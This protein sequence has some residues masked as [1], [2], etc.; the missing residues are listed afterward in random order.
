MN[1]ESLEDNF[2]VRSFTKEDLESAYQMIQDLPTEITINT[3]IHQLLSPNA[4]NPDQLQGFV[5]LSQGNMI[6]LCLIS[7]IDTLSITEQYAI[8]D[9][10]ALRKTQSQTKRIR[11]FLMQPWYLNQS[12]RFAR[13]VMIQSNTK[14]LVTMLDQELK[15]DHVTLRIAFDSFFPLQPRRRIEYVRG[16]REGVPVAPS[17]VHPAQIISANT[18]F[19]PRLHYSTRFVVV[20]ASSTGIGF[21]RRLLEQ[22]HLRFSNI[23]FVAA[24]RD[25]IRE[26]QNGVEMVP[27]D[28]CFFTNELQRLGFDQRVHLVADEMVAID[29]KDKCISLRHGQKLWYVLRKPPFPIPYTL[30]FLYIIL[31]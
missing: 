2:E 3:T 28:M 10:I 19:E 24:D 30:L 29:R 23:Y 12:R 7:A 16:E 15:A 20:G 8:H 31:G 26:Q 27:S 14:A 17:Y 18:I 11:L 21:V 5:A 25:F 13:D 22:N 9:Y 4:P 6:G 1:R